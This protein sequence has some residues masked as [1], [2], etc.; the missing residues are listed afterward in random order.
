MAPVNPSTAA[1]WI[2]ASSP[3][4]V[5]KGAVKL[6]GMKLVKRCGANAG[7]QVVIAVGKAAWTKARPTRAGFMTLWPRPP[8]RALPSATA[9]NAATAVIQSGKAGGRV[10]ASSSPVITALKSPTVLALVDSRQASCSVSTATATETNIRARALS[11][12]CQTA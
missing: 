2:Q 3:G 1:W 7:V 8:N 12:N 6:V 9:T 5:V 10:R 4:G 11:P